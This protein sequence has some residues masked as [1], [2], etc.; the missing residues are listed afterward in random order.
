MNIEE[1]RTRATIT[2]SEAADLC[3]V[4][5]TTMY[6]AIHRGDAPVLKLSGRFVVPVV[7]LLRML[8][9]DAGNATAPV[10]NG[11]GTHSGASRGA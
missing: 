4:A 1:A 2:V 8:G 10:G 6:A 7:P 11:G 3:G 5:V 9:V